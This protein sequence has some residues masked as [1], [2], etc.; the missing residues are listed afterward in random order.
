[1]NLL[2]S[3][4]P[5][6]NNGHIV[7]ILVK[8]DVELLNSPQEASAIALCLITAVP[9]DIAPLKETCSRTVPLNVSMSYPKH[10]EKPSASNTANGP[11]S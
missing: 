11:R 7:D 6:M 3:S 4:I 9:Q 10:N 2:I 5:P 8:D 1:M